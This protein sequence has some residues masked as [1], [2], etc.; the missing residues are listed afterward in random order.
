[1]EGGGELLPDLRR[2]LPPVQP[3]GGPAGRAGEAGAD[4]LHRGGGPGALLFSAGGPLRRADRGPGHR[5]DPEQDLLGEK[6]GDDRQGGPVPPGD[7]HAGAE[8][9]GRHAVHGGVS[10]SAVEGGRLAGGGDAAGQLPRLSGGPGGPV[11]G[12][13]GA[14]RDLPGGGG[15]EPL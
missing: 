10:D 5:Q 15:G 12:A 3:G 1:M 7:L 6:S 9:L 11:P 4:P 13:D 14:E 2:L 8:H